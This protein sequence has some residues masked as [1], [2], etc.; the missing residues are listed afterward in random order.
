L[1]FGR[2]RHQRVGPARETY[3]FP[4]AS[5]LCAMPGSREPCKLVREF[6]SCLPAH[7]RECLRIF[8]S[9]GG[10]GGIG[11]YGRVGVCGHGGVGGT[12]LTGGGVFFFL[13]RGRGGGLWVFFFIG[14][15]GGVCGLPAASMLCA[16]PGSRET[17]KRVGV[18]IS[19]LPAHGRECL[20][21]FF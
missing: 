16:M 8:F 12:V 17:G 18:F 6:I 19:C 5:R 20:R 9:I 14:G 1:L 10:G 4:A 3:A 21:L 13:S 7:G 11:G 15:G 2:S